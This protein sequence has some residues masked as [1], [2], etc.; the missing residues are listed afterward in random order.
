MSSLVELFINEFSPAAD[1]KE[2]FLYIFYYPQI[3]IIIKILLLNG[4]EFLTQR[5]IIKGHL[6]PAQEKLQEISSAFLRQ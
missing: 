4:S 3:L 6:F 1:G 5:G 2:G